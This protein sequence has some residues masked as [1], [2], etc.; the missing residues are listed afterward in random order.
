M[1]IYL[2]GLPGVGKTHIGKLLAH[3]LNIKFIDLDDTIEKKSKLT[4]TEIFANFG[5]DAFRQIEARELS[6]LTNNRAGFILA[7]GGGTPCFYNNIN[8]LIK[9]GPVIWI[10]AGMSR[11]LEH[12]QNDN[13]NKRPMFSNKSQYDIKNTLVQMYKNRIKYYKQAHICHNSDNNSITNLIIEIKQCQLTYSKL[14][15]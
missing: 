12:I 5:Q 9:S 11:I 15:S 2:I 1:K 4:I 7:T 13:V 3:E 6:L 14:L 10:K 8:K